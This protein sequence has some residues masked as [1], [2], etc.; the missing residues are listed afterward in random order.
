MPVEIKVKGIQTPLKRETQEERTQEIIKTQTREFNLL[1]ASHRMPFSPSTS[2]IQYALSHR[3]LEASRKRTELQT[4][5]LRTFFDVF[6]HLI[7]L[8][9]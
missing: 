9:F 4:T 8:P 3:W 6:G 7:K 1:Q 2:A 5:P